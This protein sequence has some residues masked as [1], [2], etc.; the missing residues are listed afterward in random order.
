MRLDNPLRL[1]FNTL[2]F[3]GSA[4]SQQ[5]QAF[6]F[7]SSKLGC[8]PLP[9]PPSKG[10]I[11]SQ[12]HQAFPFT[13]FKLGCCAGQGGEEEAGAA[14]AG[15][16]HHAHQTQSGSKREGLLQPRRDPPQR[17]PRGLAQGRLE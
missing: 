14:A 17:P 10:S 5:Q 11:A 13:I 4:A 6:P 2:P 15:A 16:V 3:K 9:H 12:Q 7:T 1:T 8:T